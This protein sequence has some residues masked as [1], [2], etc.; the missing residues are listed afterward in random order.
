MEQVIVNGIVI[1]LLEFAEIQSMKM[2]GTVDFIE[3]IFVGETEYKCEG[4]Y[5]LFYSH[6]SKMFYAAWNRYMSWRDYE[7]SRSKVALI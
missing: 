6:N 5:K 7:L 4:V 1:N 3:E 2:V